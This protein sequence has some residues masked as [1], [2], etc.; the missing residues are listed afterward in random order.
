MK[1]SRRQFIKGVA[2]AGALACAGSLIDGRR[3]F[4]AG[5]KS[6][7]FRVDDCPIPDGRL[8][9][10]GL[11]VLLD[12]LA[13]NHIHFYQTAARFRV[14]LCERIIQLAFWSH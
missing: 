4:S 6:W 11:D 1:F 13:E 14:I 3:A 9:H 12:L 8:E 2:A 10:Q 5:D 7:I